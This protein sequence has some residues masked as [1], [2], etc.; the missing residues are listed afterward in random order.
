MVGERTLELGIVRRS[1][2]VLAVRH[3]TP[4]DGVWLRCQS[5]LVDA[6]PEVDKLTYFIQGR[7]AS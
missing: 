4:G 7:Y 1:S 6:G 5:D 3:E 2:C